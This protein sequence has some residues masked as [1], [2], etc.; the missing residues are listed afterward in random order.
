M[1]DGYGEGATNLHLIDRLRPSLV[2]VAARSQSRGHA[3]ST[4]VVTGLVRG[5][6]NLGVGTC[7]KG[8]ESRSLLERV[9]T[10]GTYAAQGNALAPV[11][12][13][14]EAQDKLVVP[15]RLGF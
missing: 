6:A 15:A 4:D 5:V 9:V 1:L 11:G 3:Y 2:K 14:T 12:S 7:V 8:I 13:L 10:I